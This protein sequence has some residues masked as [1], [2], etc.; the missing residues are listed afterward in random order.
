MPRVY[1]ETAS[2]PVVDDYGDYATL[3]ISTPVVVCGPPGSP[4]ERRA[5]T[6]RVE[7]AVTRELSA[8][9]FETKAGRHWRATQ[10]R[11]ATSR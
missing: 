11:E 5:P 8:T 2:V 4:E 7:G 1:Y 6:Y 9:E 3:V 10:S